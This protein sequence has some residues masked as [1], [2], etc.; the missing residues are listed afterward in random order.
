M[1]RHVT[2]QSSYLFVSSPIVLGVGK[3]EV[4][5]LVLQTQQKCSAW[6]PDEATLKRPTVDSQ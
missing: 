1:T 3:N 2:S 4:V 6:S 5:L